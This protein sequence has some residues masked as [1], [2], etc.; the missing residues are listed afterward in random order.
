[1]AA[2]ISLSKAMNLDV[3]S[4]GVETA[5]QVAQLQGMGCDTGQGYFFAKPMSDVDM[6]KQLLSVRTDILEESDLLFGD[7]FEDLMDSILKWNNEQPRKIA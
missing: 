3:T 1:M 4:E 7:S 2:I 5:A 6:E